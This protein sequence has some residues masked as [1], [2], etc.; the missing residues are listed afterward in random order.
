MALKLRVCTALV[1]DHIQVPGTTGGSQTPVVLAS[2]DLMP[3]ICI[4]L[5]IKQMF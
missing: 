1:E 3:T 2:G 4:E 5:K